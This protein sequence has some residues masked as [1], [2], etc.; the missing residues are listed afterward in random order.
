M[1]IITEQAALPDPDCLL[2]VVAVMYA[3]GFCSSYV[4]RASKLNVKPGKPSVSIKS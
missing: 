1:G 3:G 2:H 4:F